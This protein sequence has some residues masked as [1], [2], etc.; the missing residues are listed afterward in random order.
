MKQILIIGGGAAGLACA[1]AAAQAGARVTVLEKRGSAGGNG[2]YAEGVFGA[3]SRLQKRNNIDADPDVLF[4]EAMEFS[5]WKADGRLTRALIDASGPTVDWLADMGVPFTRVLH[6]MPNQSPE[7]FHMAYPAPTGARVMEVL[8]AQ[9]AA[10]GVDI[11]LNARCLSL[12]MENGAVTGAEAETDGE[13]TK[14]QAD[15]VLI[16]TGG[17]AGD[18]DKMRA[19][20]PGCEPGAYMHL[21]GIPMAGD[22]LTL[23]ESAGASIVKDIAIEGCAPVFKGRSEITG[24]IR[25]EDCL[26]VNALGR[27][28]C[29]E[30]ICQN[31]ILGQNAVARQPGKMCWAILDSEALRR[32]YEGLPPMMADPAITENGMTEL[33]TALEKELAA[34]SVFQGDSL[35]ALAQ[36]AGID[37]ETLTQEVADYNAAC[38]QGHDGLFAKDR[39]YLK[40][41]NKAPYYAVRAGMDIIT[42]HGGVAVSDHMQVIRPS[43]QPIPGLYAAG[44]DISGVDSG[45]YSVTLSGHAFGFSLA[46]G[47][48]AAAEMMLN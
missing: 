28:F 38:A 47:R 46:G 40:P 33:Y 36:A 30:S 14:F 3:G 11:R 43:G 45:D 24:L 27:R 21:K 23:A 5:H 42:T 48:L 20:I 1:V 18:P 4:R 2:R 25:R 12:T 13:R 6:H 29:D 35:E 32:A 16:A 15:S 17:F 31:F 8:K 34:G 9:C 10:L 44:I 19:M 26:W 41:I 7:V 22:G 39:R 37:P